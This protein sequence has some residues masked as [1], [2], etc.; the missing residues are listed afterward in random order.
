VLFAGWLLLSGHITAQF[1]LLGAVSCAL[2]MWL[3]A[4]MRLGPRTSVSA[5]HPSAP[6]PWRTIKYVA[7]LGREI[8]LSNLKVAKMILDPSL[9]IRPVLFRAPTGQKTDFGRVIFANSITLTPGTISV[10]IPGDGSHILVH[11]LHEDFSWNSES[12]D[13]DTRIAALGV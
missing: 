13:M 9:P 8:F 10:E 4:R 3:S 6:H 1:L 11:S 5:P 12:C 2:V 7:W